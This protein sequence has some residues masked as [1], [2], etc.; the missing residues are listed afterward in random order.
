MDAGS[1]HTHPDDYRK[2]GLGDFDQT[3]GK[4]NEG[5]PT[6]PDQGRTE[7]L[8]SR[9]RS[10]DQTRDARIEARVLNGEA[11]LTGIAPN[12]F[13]RERAEQLAREVEG[14]TDVRNEIKIQKADEEEGG[15]ILT[16][17]MPGANNSGST[18]RS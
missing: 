3:Q 2:L 10:H 12:R 11:V 6:G 4:A 13:A 5:T 16:T 9:I 14:V 17:H 7:D 1:P 15:P 18:Q 8:I